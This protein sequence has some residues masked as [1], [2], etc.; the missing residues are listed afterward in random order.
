MNRQEALRDQ[1]LKYEDAI[2]T[3]EKYHEKRTE[4]NIK[5]LRDAIVLIKQDNKRRVKKIMEAQF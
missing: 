5:E 4:K 2:R 1:R 3:V